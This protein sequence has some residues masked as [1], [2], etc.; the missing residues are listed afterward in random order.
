M[1]NSKLLSGII[2][3]LNVMKMNDIYFLP[4]KT[5]ALFKDFEVNQPPEEFLIFRLS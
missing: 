2:E 3:S 1:Y 4:F 5:I